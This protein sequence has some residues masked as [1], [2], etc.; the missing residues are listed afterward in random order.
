MN[1]LE[2][3][4]MGI[5]KGHQSFIEAVKDLTDAQIHFR[6]LGKGN[7]IAFILWHYARTED[8]LMNVSLQKKKPIW[9]VAGWDQ[10]FG[11]DA[12]SQGTGMTSE[13]AAAIRIN[14]LGGFLKYAEDVFG[15]S[16][17]Y[18]ETAKEETLDEV[19]DFSVIGKLSVRNVIGGMVLDHAAG[20]LGEIWYVK[21]LQG[22]KG[23]PV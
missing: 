18:L 7:S 13:Q 2:Y 5:T 20:H 15:A 4:R 12:R 9:N 3:F 23:S 19:R 8:I 16:E 21:G 22:L 11:M 14:D 1:T 17:A 6:P 10:K